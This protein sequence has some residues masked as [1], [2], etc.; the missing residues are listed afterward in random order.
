MNLEGNHE[1]KRRRWH[2]VEVKPRT[3]FKE[4]AM[5]FL[6]IVCDPSKRVKAQP[7]NPA[8]WVEKLNWDDG[9]EKISHQRLLCLQFPKWMVLIDSRNYPLLY[10]LK[11]STCHLYWFFSFSSLS[12]KEKIHKLLSRWFGWFEIEFLVVHTIW[13]F[14]YKS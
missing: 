1:R 9:E 4:A 11:A 2:T 10:F 13:I 12:R 8:V 3:E 14:I 7:W 6:F 5:D